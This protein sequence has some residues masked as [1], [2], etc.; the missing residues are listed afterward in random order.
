MRT[1]IVSRSLV[2]AVPWVMLGLFSSMTAYGSDA[3]HGQLSVPHFMYDGYV[4]VEGRSTRTPSRAPAQTAA[5]HTHQCG[6]F[7]RSLRGRASV[8]LR[9]GRWLSRRPCT[10][11]PSS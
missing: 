10:L 5:H 3:L 8:S 7:G 4:V 1:T 2:K 11:S 9:C 6:L